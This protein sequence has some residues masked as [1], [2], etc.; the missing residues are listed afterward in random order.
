MG[1]RINTNVASLTAQTSAA[2][3]NRN[4]DSSLAKLSSG[5]RINKAAD[6]ASGLAIANSLRAQA[7]SLGQA[8]SNGNDAIGLIQ[9]ADGALSEYSNILDTIKTKSVQ[10]A[11]DGQNSTSRLAIQKDINRLLENLNNIAKTTSFNGQK[12]LSGTFTN[13]EFQVGANANETIKT[14]I[15]SAETSQIG[16]TSRATLTVAAGENQLTL[17]SAISGASITLESVNL[18]SNNDPAN[19]VGA[20]ADIINKHSAETGI[21]AKAVVSTTTAS[22]I[23]AGTTGSDFAING[24]NIGAI[25]VSANDSDGALLTAINNKATETGVTATKTADG[26]ITL[27]T[28]DGRAISVTGDVSG[29]MGTTADKMSTIGHLEVVQAGSSTFQITGSD[30]GKAVGA[31]ITTTGTTNM[32]QDSVLAIGSII[33]TGSTLAAGTKTG[34]ILTA[35]VGMSLVTDSSTADMTLAVGSVLSAGTIINK[36]TV[37][38]SKIAVSGD[39]TL[40]SSMFVKAGST[41]AA[42]TVFD[43]GTVL[44][45]D[46]TVSGTT[47][48]SG[49]TLTQDLT[50]SSSIILSKDMTI[51]VEATTPNSTIGAGSSLLAGTVIGADITLSSS[52]TL[53]TDMTLKAGSTLAAGTQIAAG[54]VL[55]QSVVVTAA[56]YTTTQATDLKVGSILGSAST[57]KEGS[58]LGGEVTINALT[59]KDDMLVKAGSLLASGTVLKAGT[60]I[61]QDLT[62]A[63]AGNAGVGIK[64]GTVLGTD[65]TTT[66]DIYTLND[67]TLLKGSGTAGSIAAN[68]KLAANGGN[69]NSASLSDTVF[70]N[71]SKIDVTTL[72][73]AMKAIDTVSAAMT[74]LDTIRS[75]LG[76][77]QNQITSTINNISVTQ[78]NVKSAESGIRDVDFAAES[79]NFSKFNILAQSG[80]YAMSQ[81]NSV[82]QNVLKL[83]Q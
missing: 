83:L 9:T 60:L 36:D 11:S 80:S 54:S 70:S 76:S 64:A 34:V 33:A 66:A 62:A 63:Q 4:L 22:A 10:A 52:S 59:L 45:Q 18:L 44:Q 50:L 15:A 26:K 20:L 53:A 38:A 23:A 24:V 37:L 49:M 47:Y 3:N 75:D 28:G 19:G 81:A 82:Q 46:M 56:S 79:A 6:D 27:A 7:S 43:A 71:L 29:V 16:Q 41:L 42:N 13:K 65:L 61:T 69:Q 55:G 77:V 57:I 14:S 32:V 30:L 35:T 8:V 78:V 72:E 21:T 68:S 2:V 17:K 5:L 73:G 48:K 1:F 25:N 67:M 58:S 31:D 39:T 40:S 74:N 51:S 12:L